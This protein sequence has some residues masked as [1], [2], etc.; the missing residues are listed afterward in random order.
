M[1]YVRLASYTTRIMYKKVSKIL[2]SIDVRPNSRSKPKLQPE[3]YSPLPGIGIHIL[4]NLWYRYSEQFQK[5]NLRNIIQIIEQVA[6]RQSQS[7]AK[8]KYSRL[9]LNKSY[10]NA[11]IFTQILS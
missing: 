7:F 5:K 1:A 2:G 9:F 3:F 6:K 10:T 8:Q 4:Y 11:E